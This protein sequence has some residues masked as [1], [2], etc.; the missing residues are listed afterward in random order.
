MT[1]TAA[2]ESGRN[3]L[4]VERDR[5]YAVVANQGLPHTTLAMP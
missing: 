5:H 1:P 3:C 4:S 2:W